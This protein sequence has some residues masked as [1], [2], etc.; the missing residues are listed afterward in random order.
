M[1]TWPLRHCSHGDNRLNPDRSSNQENLSH[2][3]LMQ[4]EQTRLLYDGLPQAQVSNL[5]LSILL[6]SVMW[7]VVSFAQATGWLILIGCVVIWRVV[8][9][10][11]YRRAAQEQAP[12]VWLRY[13]RLSVISAGV[14]WG[15]ASLLLFPPG[16]ISHQV[17]LAFV[18]AGLSSAAI[19][20]LSADRI[21]ALGF[22]VPA[23][24]PLVFN[25]VTEGG[26]VPLAMGLMVALFI[27]FLSVAAQR[28]QK[29]LYEIV[30]LRAGAMQTEA[31]LMRQQQLAALIL[32]A[33]LKFIREEN[34]QDIF[35]HL[36]S[37]IL[38]LSGSEYGYIGE[39]IFTPAGNPY[40]KTYA[41]SNIETHIESLDLSQANAAVN[42]QLFNLKET[43]YSAL[44]CG[45]TVIVNNTGCDMAGASL[46]VGNLEIS[47]LLGIPISHDGEL[48]SMLALA[49]RKGG[50]D[51]ELIDFLQ[52]LLTTV[53][54]MIDAARTQHRQRED[55]IVLARLS[56]VASQTTNGVVI[57]D[58]NGLVE[59]INEGFTRI[60]GYTLEDIRGQSPGKL[61][62]GKETAPA[63]IAQMHEALHLCSAFDVE[64]INY[65]KD[66]K[67]YW[68]HISCNPLLDEDGS[69]QGFMAIESDVS[70]RKQVERMKTEFVSTVSH[71]LRTPLTS[72][73]GSLGLISAGVLGELAPRMRQM[74]DIAYKNSQKLTLLINDLLDIEKLTAG[75]VQ[76]DM[77]VQALMPLL[78]QAILDN[79]A[80]ADQYRV[81]YEFIEYNQHVAIN[82]D[83][84]RLQQVMANLLS[85]AAKFSPVGGTVTVQVLSQNEKIRI[86]VIDKGPGITAEFRTRIF[87]KFS[88]ADSS[89]TRQKG[90]TGLGLAITRELVE[91]MGG[92][93]GFDSLEGA[94]AT[95]YVE[96]PIAQAGK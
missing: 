21:S 88:Q 60:S 74:L 32:R 54:Q 70:E 86:Q 80:Y 37:D 94:G 76:L 92:Q 64:V 23:L 61:L 58:K 57:T 75:K 44:K 29:S 33:Q 8:L 51:Q 9:Y 71:E 84:L 79:Q 89:D 49:N 68:I 40:L 38:D 12:A 83:A 55:Q 17:F 39:V 22:I 63:A 56:R 82:V 91:R 16:D 34:R 69:L 77:K 30:R 87:Q 45:K 41:I 6:I 85:N 31:K 93:I 28:M 67:P 24:L 62:Q 20:S 43:F 46:T 52:P 50:F 15:A 95:F 78:R 4:A 73:T 90:G 36:L 27:V 96:F 47:S 35:D 26:E 48:V 7:P 3:S 66:G 14:A 72:I 81:K 1:P 5:L 19:T 2:T 42:A 65:H 10:L 25:F 11:F 59:W 53:G 18:L 13:F